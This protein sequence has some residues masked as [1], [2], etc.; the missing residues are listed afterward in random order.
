MI[1][2]T[3]T[4]ITSPNIIRMLNSLAKIIKN[5]FC[6]LL[7]A[8][9]LA[10][11]VAVLINFYV[12]FS[13][14]KHIVKSENV[15]SEYDCVLIL[16]CSARGGIPSDMLKDRLDRGVE[17][18]KNGKCEKILISGDNSGK[19][20]NEV[21]VMKNYLVNEG[22]PE[23]AIISDNF[24]F[25]TYESMYRA[26]K[27]YELRKILIVTQKYHLY[28]SVFLARKFGM[29]A[30]GV[31]SMP[32]TYVTFLYDEAREFL[33]RNKD[34]IFSIIQPPPTSTER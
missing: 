28:R 5:S 34:F 18:Y 33:A 26:A 4:A 24:G 6:T 11:A 14:K 1:L 20:Y 31:E 10:G 21:G 30:K 25:S 32:N 9:L 8:C 7:I 17:L 16:G 15:N 23:D 22:V 12:V 3:L 13:S 2:L 19:H 27:V 29:E